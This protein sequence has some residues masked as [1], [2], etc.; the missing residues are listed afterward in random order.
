[1]VGGAAALALVGTGAVYLTGSAG[2]KDAGTVSAAAAPTTTAAGAGPATTPTTVKSSAPAVVTGDE[3][4]ATFQALLPRGETTEAKGRGTDDERMGGTFVGAD[5]VFDDGQGKSLIQIGIQKHHPNQ[6]QPLTCPKDFKP[7]RVDSCTVT[8]LPDGSRLMLEQ[9]Y[10]YSDGRADTKEWHASLSGADGRDINVSEWNAPAEKGARDSRPNPPL[11]LD[12]LKAIVTDKSWDRMVAAVKFNGIDTD[13]IDPG[14]SLPDREAVLVGLLPQ[15]VTV[16]GRSGSALAA[17]FQ[18]ARGEAA[19]SLVLRVENW[20][21]SA[22]NPGQQAFKD[23]VTLPDGTK[24][25]VLGGPDSKDKQPVRVNV[26]H[27]DGMEVMVAQ[28]P[29]GQ[30]LLTVEQLKAIA[31]GPAWKPKK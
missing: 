17:E 28:G 31:A 18:L 1:M 24:V 19:G 29:T 16:A 26:L 9:G 13:A 15:G 5:V 30:Q 25:L 8:P 11:T 2:A 21:K 7:A 6:A 20:A 4:L 12:Q 22:D 10:E 27:P 23:A 14:L 3:V